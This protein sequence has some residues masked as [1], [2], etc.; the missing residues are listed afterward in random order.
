[1]NTMQIGAAQVAQSGTVSLVEPEGG[2]ERL[3]SVGI[4]VSDWQL[5][6]IRRES[7][8][9][10]PELLI[11]KLYPAHNDGSGNI[12]G[13][14]R[15]PWCN[16]IHAHGIDGETWKRPHCSEQL[17]PF[18]ENFPKPDAYAVQTVLD[19]APKE[20]H[21]ELEI[22]REDLLNTAA[23]LRDRRRRFTR[24][25][26]GIALQ[27]LIR[28]RVLEDAIADDMARGRTVEQ[29]RRNA[30]ASTWRKAGTGPMRERLTA[31][32][33]DAYAEAGRVDGK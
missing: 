29:A 12:D 6:K 13:V 24:K 14:G 16:R 15:C 8:I 10:D 18:S 25:R 30:L 3:K 20:I 7:G 31:A 5:E 32:L 9:L 21:R 27:A 11:I 22:G 2:I 17:P 23:M 28:C 4:E 33:L 19:V 26:W 1:M